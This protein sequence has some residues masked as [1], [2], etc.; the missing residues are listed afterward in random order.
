M[1]ENELIVKA[2]SD[3]VAADADRVR[4]AATCGVRD[5]ENNAAEYSGTAQ[6]A[7]MLARAYRTLIAE[8]ASHA[9]AAV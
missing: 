8:E 6:R 5:A 3:A 2:V 1:T 9:P 7:Y 4:W